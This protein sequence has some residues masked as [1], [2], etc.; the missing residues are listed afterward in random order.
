MEQHTFIPLLTKIYIPLLL[1]TFSVNSFGADVVHLNP[2]SLAPF[3]GY[4]FS[5]DKEKQLRLDE[6][7]LG[8]YKSLSDHQSNILKLQSD[9]VDKLNTM[10]SDKDK[11]IDNLN[12]QVVSNDNSFLS[13]AFFF[14][15]GAGIT[16]LLGYG[17]YKSK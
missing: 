17:I 6:S 2:N 10:L 3:E 5:P 15:V 16:G 14:V 8:Y 11:Q 9:S 4:L 12:K 1:L 7:D 13:K